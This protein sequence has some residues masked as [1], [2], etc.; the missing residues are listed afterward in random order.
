MVVIEVKTASLGKQEPWMEGSIE[1]NFCFAG[2][3]MDTPLVQPQESISAGFDPAVIELSFWDSIKTSTNPGDFEEY[4]KQ[5]PMGSFASLARNRLKQTA[6]VAVVQPTSID[7]G[8]KIEMVWLPTGI[9]MGKYEVTQGQWKAVMGNNP[10]GFSNCGETCPVEQVSYDDINQFIQRLNS[11]TGKNYRLP[12]EDEWFS[13]CQA[14]S[15]T[16]YC[17]SNEI[18]AVAWHDTNSSNTT[19][20]VGQ[21]QPN[22]YGLYDMSGNVWEWTR[23]LYEA[24]GTRL[25]VRGGSWNNTFPGTPSPAQLSGYV[26][27]SRFSVLGF[28]LIQEN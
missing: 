23:S 28:R 3:G 5:Y 10:S 24:N 18:E 17:G 13:A 16:Q 2:C 1:G 21:K 6:P 22:A 7:L 19:H 11:M 27:T 25:A 14:G 15:N 9:S 26:L 8:P 20:P 12:T 4:L